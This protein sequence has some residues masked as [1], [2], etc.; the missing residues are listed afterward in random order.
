MDHSG[1]PV[2]QRNLANVRRALQWICWAITA[3]LLGF[4]VGVEPICWPYDPPPLLAHAQPLCA[5]L[6]FLFL[7]ANAVI[8]TAPAQA[9]LFTLTFL[10][11][12]AAALVTCH[13]LSINV[14]P[15][16]M[17]PD[18][19]G[20]DARP[21]RAAAGRPLNPIGIWQFDERYGYDH[22]PNR[23]GVHRAADFE[24]T[25]T[26]DGDR[27]RVTPT[28]EAPEGRVFITGCSYTFGHGVEDDECY[29]AVLAAKHWPSYKIQNRAVCGYGTAHAYL[30]VSDEL[31]APERDPP[32]LVIYGMIP[33]H[34]RRNYIRKTYVR[35]IVA[36][37]FF[38][39]R[40][41]D[42]LVERRGYPHFELVDGK[43]EFRGLIGLE[44]A[45]ADSPLLKY[46]EIALTEAFLSEMHKKCS[47]NG[48][49]FV[50]LLAPPTNPGAWES[51]KRIL[52][53]HDTPYLDVSDIPFEGFP[54]DTH[55][56]PDDHER[57]AE[58]IAGSF[59]TD[60]L[61][62]DRRSRP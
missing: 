12:L 18:R 40:S 50:V 61:Y 13:C 47:E 42:P 38:R 48:V 62:P 45:L 22:F 58:A 43:L 28:P 32:S 19:T 56:N 14:I 26:I 30:L 20:A 10:T 51:I 17:R 55:P 27:C 46:A 4:A 41:L 59:I 23:E 36:C 15:A 44:G 7:L 49:P 24:V 6:A 8:L 33:D 5:G 57:I 52:D 39:K 11:A 35:H 21:V 31:D 53:K 29:P 3:A 1:R 16:W 37:P 2:N 60:I 54:R 34:L 25:Y 9:G